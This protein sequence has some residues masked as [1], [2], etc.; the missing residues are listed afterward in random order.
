M[1]IEIIPCQKQWPTEF[2]GIASNL[3]V[4]LGEFALRIEH[5]GSTSLPGLAAKDVIDIQTTVM[6]LD[7]TVEARMVVLWGIHSLKVSG[8][9]T[10]QRQSQRLNPH[11]RNGFLC[12]RKN[13]A[14]SIHMFGSRAGSISGIYCHWDYNYVEN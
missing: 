9:I 12:H 8:E 14:G 11:G 7:S 3:S 5:I 2:Q 13:N 6:T 1:V 4:G 10:A